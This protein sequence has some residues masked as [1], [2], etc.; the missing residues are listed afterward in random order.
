MIRLD[1]NAA[2]RSVVVTLGLTLL[3]WRYLRLAGWS[4]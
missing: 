2:R 4:A 1:D 3:A